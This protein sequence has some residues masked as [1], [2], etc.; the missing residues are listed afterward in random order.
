[1]TLNIFGKEIIFEIKEKKKDNRK[2]KFKIRNNKFLYRFIIGIMVLFGFGVVIEM[3]KLKANYT[4]GSIAQ[5]DIIAYKTTSYFVD[6]L[7]ANIEEKIRKTTTPEYDKKKEV[8]KETVMEIHSFFRELREIEDKSDANLQKFINDNKYNLTVEELKMIIERNNDTGYIVNLIS[9]ISDLYS[10][11]IYSVENLEK[12]I[13][14]R[15][16][17]I[18]RLDLKL[19]RNFIRPNLVINE[20]K[21]LEK[22]DENI[23][24]LKDKEVKIYKGD[25]IVKKG[26]IIDEDVYTKLEKLNLVRGGDKA[27]K[28]F[29]MFL[30]FVVMAILFYFILKKFSKKI[31]ESNAFYPSLITISIINTLYILFLDE[32]IL[33]YLLP[34]AMIPIILTIIGDKAFA[35]SFTF[36]NI[37]LLSREETWFLV[38]IAVSL[39]AVY[40][41]D[42]ISNRT[43]IVKI[44]IF[45]GI[46]QAIMSLGY[47][48]INQLEFRN[49]LIL[50]ISSVFSGIFTGML[51]LALLPYLENTFEILTDIKLLE[52]S[53]FSHTLL[54]QLLVTAP[55]TFHHSIM[56]GALAESGAEAIGANATFAR[57]A[58]Y[59]HDIGK[60]KRPEFFVEN[61]R[62]GKNP[63]N[64]IKP[65]LSALIITSHTKDGYI[66]GKQNKLPKEILNIILEHHGTTLVQFF[67]YKALESGDEVIENDFRYS[68]PKPKTKEAGIIFLADTIE[69]AVRSTEDKSKENLENLIRY[70]IKYKIDDNQ[71][72][73]SELTLSEIEKVIKAFL[74]TLQG[75]YHE[76]IKY[77][78]VDRN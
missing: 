40:S 69:A 19:L 67:Y 8:T 12:I 36:F 62:E 4:I 29:G 37:I 63:H 26:E 49:L 10:Y 42:K 72:S 2:E 76:R 34:F 60:M 27:I 55:G 22:I 38:S 7:D 25:V 78:K 3:S 43:E 44:G 51:S 64:K 74:N 23:K 61:Q 11:G 41:A 9:Q 17:T 75:A 71:L 15:E 32:R 56:V 21:T 39:V 48:L 18:D 65:S 45:I 30:T 47:G 57:I 59:Y 20:K 46:F 52:L 5:S 14:K 66:I 70:L 28:I 24:S 68:G 33:I 1:M 73:E 58:S 53:D 54:K 77:P 35:L 31:V 16:I 13:T 6:I 50:I